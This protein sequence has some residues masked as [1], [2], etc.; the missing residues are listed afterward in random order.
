MAIM[1]GADTFFWF[2]LTV[3]LTVALVGATW[4]MTIS[5]RDRP[6]RRQRRGEE[7]VERYGDIEEDRAPVPRFLSWLYIGLAVWAVAYALWTGING[8]GL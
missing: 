7:T 4:Y 2:W 5:G 3:L 1:Q 6:P 8:T